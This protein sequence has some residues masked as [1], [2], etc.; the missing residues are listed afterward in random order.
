MPLASIRTRY[1]REPGDPAAPGGL[2][3][4]ALCRRTH[5][6]GSSPG[7]R[8]RT[9]CRPPAGCAP[10]AGLA[11]TTRSVASSEPS[12]IQTRSM[13]VWS[14]RI[15]TISVKAAGVDSRVASARL[16]A[17]QRARL[18]LAIAGDLRPRALERGELADHD[19]DEQQEQHRDPLAAAG[20]W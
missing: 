5:C 12:E 16:S 13:P 8:R 1:T 6:A 20:R 14:R 4:A 7:V 11:A 19:S 17:E 15:S 3:R 18:A 2:A 10:S 9:Y